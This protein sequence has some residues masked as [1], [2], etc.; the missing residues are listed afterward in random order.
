M[1]LLA[2]IGGTNARFAL[3]EP[4]GM[5][6][7][8][9]HLLVR[10]FAEPSD[11]ID[12]YLDERK[13]TEAVIAVATAIE[14]DE[15][16][17]T[18]SHWAFSIQALRQ[19]HGLE[20][21]A[22]INDFVAQALAMPHLAAHEVEQMGGGA[23]SPMRPIGVLGPGTGLGVSALIPHRNGWTALPTEGGHASFAP[24]DAREQAVLD[25]LR[26]RFGHVSNERLLSGQGLLNLAQALAAVDDRICPATSPEGVSE[27]A[28]EGQCP[29]CSEALAMFSAALGSV[30]GSLALIYGA[31]GGVFVAGGIC[32]RLG[33]LFDRG[34]FR[35]RFEDKGRMRHYVEPIPTWLV[36][37]RDTGLIGAAH[38]RGSD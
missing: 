21:L 15:V 38:Y 17:F 26:R 30:A 37:R 35:R 13:V 7:E 14:R 25:Q 31:Q 2:D 22:V 11:A 29:S 10:D 24:A 20:Q 33:P 1:R 8:E 16:R 27:A 19:R 28:R 36:V 32:L 12:A 23:G 3:A 18:N 9:R 34:A 4:G 5:P 6:V